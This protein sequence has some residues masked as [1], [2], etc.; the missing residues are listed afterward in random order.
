MKKPNKS[1]KTITPET[2]K[3]TPQIIQLTPEYLYQKGKEFYKEALLEQENSKQQQKFIN[4]LLYFQGAMLLGSEDA[5]AYL[6]EFYSRE[7]H[8]GINNEDISNFTKIIGTIGKLSNYLKLRHSVCFKN[9]NINSNDELQEYTIIEKGYMNIMKGNWLK[10]PVPEYL[11]LS[12]LK[13]IITSFNSKVPPEYQLITDES[14]FECK[15]EINEF[16]VLEENNKNQ[17]TVTTPTQEPQEEYR[18]NVK[19]DD[20]GLT[21]ATNCIIS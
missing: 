15:E 8:L 11:V 3:V 20:Y 10:T 6:S 14:I 5:C 7:N 2:I 4:T 1:P 16:T 21:G 19:N 9:Y 18:E 17:P 12:N 13:S